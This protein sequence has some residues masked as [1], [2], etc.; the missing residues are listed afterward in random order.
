MAKVREFQ[1]YEGK[2]H[3][4]MTTETHLANMFA[5]DPYYANRMM[6]R[7]FEVSYGETFL[8]YVGQFSRHST[9]ETEYRW[10]M[11]GMHE[12]NIPL[13]AAWA[14][15]S[16][17]TA[18]STVSKPGANSTT[19]YLDFNEMLFGAKEVIV[20][21]RPDLYRV[22]IKS[23]P[24]IISTGT[25]R[26]ECELIGDENVWIPATELAAG[27]RWSSDGGLVTDTLSDKG[28]GISHAS[29]FELKNRMTQFRM[30][31]TIPGNMFRQGKENSMV[32]KFK[33]MSEDGVENVVW[34]DHLTHEF[35]RKAR[36]SKARTAYFSKSNERTDGTTTNISQNGYAAES[37]AGFEEM[38]LSTNRH[39]YHED[40]LSLRY[41]TDTIIDAAEGKRDYTNMAVTIG[42]GWRGL[43]ML[44]EMVQTELGASGSF[45]YMGDSTGRAYDRS[46]NQKNDIHVSFGNIV[47]YSDIFGIKVK[48]MHLP[49]KDDPVRNK[50]RHPNGGLVS[51]YELDIMDFGKTASGEDNIQQVELQGQEPILAVIPGMR[52]GVNNATSGVMGGMKEIASAVDGSVI[53]YMDW[54]GMVV[55][56]P[57]RIIQFKPSILYS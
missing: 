4:G 6:E 54:T 1:I 14:D 21:M 26:Y 49:H 43:R 13:V 34:I 45:P 36:V 5:K 56:N 51:S 16:G 47:G 28:Y 46:G 22:W 57:Q 41:L 53:H 33:F 30:Q 52:S 48:F 31:E 9:P 2:F 23:E 24:S 3:N 17:T 40:G 35:L 39:P 25:Y 8:S 55:W 19:F 11:Q 7:V 50:L 37:G 44:K 38:L 42:A 10:K 32:Y 18:I 15:R 27:T 29:P 12:K 20:G